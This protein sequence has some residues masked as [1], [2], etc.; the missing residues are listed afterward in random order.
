MSHVKNPIIVALDVPTAD[1][2]IKLA[3]Q[4]APAVGAFKIGSELF[5]AAGPDIVRRI[6]DTG[7][8]VFLD[9]K[10]HDIPNTVAKAVASA[11]RLD[12]QMLTIHTSGALEMMRAAEQSAQQTAQQS[13]RTAPLVLGVTVLTSMDGNA[14]SEIGCQANVGAQ[15]ERLA[16]LAVNAG[17]RGLVCSPLEIAALRQILPSQV[18]LVTPG[19]RTGAEKA[20]DQ[21][22]TLSPREAIDAGASWLVIGRPIYA[23]ENPRAAAEAIFKSFS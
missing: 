11:T 23:A 12:V 8:A 2:A 20:D 4:V 3:Q 13:G 18:Q 10:F 17:L 6:R 5:T 15:V 16:T 9:L 1:A 7:A 19:I 14:L 22:R 21:K